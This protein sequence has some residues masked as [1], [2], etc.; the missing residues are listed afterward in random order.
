MRRPHAMHSRFNKFP[1][2]KSQFTTTSRPLLL[3]PLHPRS[4]RGKD[5]SNRC[6]Y[7]IVLGH[8]RAPP[9]TTIPPVDTSLIPRP[10]LAATHHPAPEAHEYTCSRDAVFHIVRRPGCRT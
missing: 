10:I 9:T 8:T 3:R 6:R 5:F 7:A 4:D 2:I 1:I